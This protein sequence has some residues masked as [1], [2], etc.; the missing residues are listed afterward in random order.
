MAAFPS[1]ANPLPLASHCKLLPPCFGDRRGKVIASRGIDRL[2]PAYAR[3]LP[4]PACPGD[5][6]KGSEC[7]P[8]RVHVLARLEA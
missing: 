6:H 7:R 5:A 8:E 4:D 3:T 2:F 1:S